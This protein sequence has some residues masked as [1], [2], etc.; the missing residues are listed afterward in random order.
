MR[1]H[2]SRS[3]GTKTH[4]WA[5]RLAHRS[6]VLHVCVCACARVCACVCACP[7]GKFAAVGW[8]QGRMPGS[9][10]GREEKCSHTPSPCP[11]AVPPGKQQTARPI[12]S[13]QRGNCPLVTSTTLP[14]LQCKPSSLKGGAPVSQWESPRFSKPYQYCIGQICLM[15][16]DGT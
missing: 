11:Q 2:K 14:L 5:P 13:H 6:I 15:P 10:F 3:K 9:G 12:H 16:V 8:Q 7:L 1:N 4:W